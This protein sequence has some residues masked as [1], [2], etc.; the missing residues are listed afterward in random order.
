[1]SD[2]CRAIVTLQTADCDVI[3]LCRYR[4]WTWC[5]VVAANGGSDVTNVRL[6]GR[7]YRKRYI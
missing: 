6:S 2:T 4:L 3:V 7:E 1:V 5:L